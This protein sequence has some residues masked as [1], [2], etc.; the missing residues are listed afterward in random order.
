MTIFGGWIFLRI[1]FFKGNL[2]SWYSFFFFGGGGG[3][4][5]RY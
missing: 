4:Q 5:S 1:F 2:S 3:G